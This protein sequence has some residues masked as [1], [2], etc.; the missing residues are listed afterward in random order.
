MMQF[1]LLII[2]LQFLIS[3]CYYFFVILLQ[4]AKSTGRHKIIA[5]VQ[6][7]LQ[8]GYFITVCP[9]LQLSFVLFLKLRTFAGLYSSSPN[10]C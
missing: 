7:L 6:V 10:Y 8:V 2:V 5:N 4:S 9:V 1:I 3:V